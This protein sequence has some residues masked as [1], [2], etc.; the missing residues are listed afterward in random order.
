MSVT[1][2]LRVLR[3]LASEVRFGSSHGKLRTDSPQMKYI[4]SQYHHYRVTDQQL[5]KAQAEMEHLATTYLCYL[6]SVRRAGE[7]HQT[8][9]GKGERSVHDTA[10]LVGFKLPHDPK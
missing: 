6:Q 5:C 7:I 2:S 3:Q 1:P 10:N 9:K 4:L 8:Y